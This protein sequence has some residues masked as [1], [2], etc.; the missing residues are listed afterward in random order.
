MTQGRGGGGGG[1]GLFAAGMWPRT[2]RENDGGGV[3]SRGLVQNVAEAIYTGFAVGR[4]SIDPSMVADALFS[5]SEKD[6]G[7]GDLEMMRSQ[8]VLGVVATCVL[9]GVARVLPRCC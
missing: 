4:V 7:R 1:G 3:A 2:R 6:R 5:P 9:M 8:Q